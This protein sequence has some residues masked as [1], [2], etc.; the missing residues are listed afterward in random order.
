MNLIKSL[1]AFLFLTQS[2]IIHSQSSIS[3][4]LSDQNNQP[5]EGGTIS[6]SSQSNRYT[7]SGPK[8]EFNFTNIPFGEY[9]IN[10]SHLGFKPISE[11]I[12]I[13]KDNMTL[14]Y[15]LDTDLLNLHT[16]VLTGNF[17]PK[18]QLESSTSVSTLNSEHIQQVYPRGTANLLENIPG[19][20]TDASAGEV[21]TKVYTRGIS[22]AA[23]DDMGWYY[24]SLQEDGLPVSL[25]QHSYYSPDIFNRVDLTTGKVEALRGGT[26]SIIAMNAP[27]GVYNFISKNNS[28]EGLNGEVQ[29]QTGI[30]GDGN[31]MYR[32][33]AVIGGALGNNW[34]FNAGGHYRHDDG[35]RNTDFTFSKGGQFKFDVTKETSRGYFKLYGKYLN[36]YTNRYNGVAATNWDNPTAAFGQNF[37]NTA[38]L[39]PSFNANIP[40]GRTL[41]EGGTN[42][43][44]PANGVHAKDLAFG[45]DFSQNLGNDW[46]IKNNMK[47][48][49]KNANWQ[50]A[51]SNAFVSISD[52]TAYYLVSN[53][54]PFPVGQIVFREANSG[55]ELARID[56]SGIFSGEASQYLTDGTL[57][58]D[59]I[60]G[61]STWYKDNDADEFM[62]QLTLN[63]SWDTHD[64]N[65]GFA[66]GFSDTS[67][68]TQGSF[69][70]STY[71]NSPQM[72]QVTL[73]NPGEPVI[74]LSD[75]F[76]VSNYGGLFFTNSRAKISQVAAFANDQW[77]ISDRIQL[78]LGLRFESINHNGSNDSYAP[79]TQSG[80]LDLDE[81]TA[82][83]NN[84][85]APTGEIH[86]FDYTYNYLSYSF[87]LNYKLTRDASLFGRVSKGNKAPELNYYFNNF[88]NVPINQAG[89]IQQI[90]QVEIGV[91]SIL[92]DF[93]FT[94]TLFWSELN[95]IGISNF[96]FDG[97]TGSIFYTPMQ[98]NTSRTLGLEWESI[99]TPF[100]N[101]AFRFN[102]IIQNPKATDWTIYDASGTVDTA[103]DSIVD[104][105]GN[106]LPFNP[107]V[108]F[109]LAIEYNK[110]RVSSFLKWRYTGTREANV[111]NAFQLDAFSVFDAGLGYKITNNLSANLLVTNLFNSDGLA[112]FMGANSFG[113]NANGVTSEYIDNNPNASFIVIPILPRASLLQL[114][115]TF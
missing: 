112:N 104:Y 16:V 80:G 23:E 10:I 114:N 87:G 42:S 29:L 1:I 91:K 7:I 72:L 109:N 102:G 17:S 39:M 61:T 83:D 88:S 31:M 58:N 27:G 68:F 111:G 20:F 40:D 13:D 30:Q 94:T 46:S 33:D 4:T 82:Y 63:K 64:L 24:V 115:Y 97:D 21:F 92:K 28:S 67:V 73:E 56:N 74:A 3:G 11:R 108:M 44:N 93:S 66:T 14:S 65:F 81:T 89:E 52:P 75:E 84:I 9:T 12:K 110:N 98:F 86:E 50:T 103:D 95:N 8:G 99:Y 76:G 19:T 36:D 55:T 15:F 78:D 25:V 37:H 90:N 48:S 2:F 45:F 57:P 71:E 32:A 62:Q 79:F 96:E 34:F 69:A 59:A 100:Q 43:F 113:A 53:G 105:S 41:S 85:L 38:L 70:F 54:N 47:F 60:M 101:I 26:A 51:I 18:A 22:A 35:A 77:E 106:T 5:I 107:K 6:L 49:S